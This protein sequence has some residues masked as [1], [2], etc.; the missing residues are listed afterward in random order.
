LV[1]TE[2]STP[3]HWQQSSG[4]SGCVGV[5]VGVFGTQ[6]PAS[7]HAESRRTSQPIGQEPVPG[8]KQTSP[9]H[10]Q[11]SLRPMVGVFVTGGVPVAVG[12]LATHAPVS[13][14]AESNCGVQP[15][16]HASSIGT[17]QVLPWH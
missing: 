13:V 1:G 5:T 12:V 10:S 7:V 11:Q 6:A 16:G 9:S 2:H 15:T 3:A 17:L 4:P 8:T 14:Q